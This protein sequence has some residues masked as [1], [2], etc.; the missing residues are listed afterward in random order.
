LSE[1]IATNQENTDKHHHDELLVVK[2]FVTVKH[3]FY[4]I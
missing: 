3:D 2:G 4:L 1:Y